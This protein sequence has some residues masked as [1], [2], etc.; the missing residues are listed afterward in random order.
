MAGKRIRVLLAD[1]H[2]KVRE[3][4]IHL[5]EQFPDFEIAGQAI[6][7]Q[8][9]VRLAR[10]LMPDVIIMDVV[11]P[12]MDGI[13]ATRIIHS[14]LPQV[15]VLGLSSSEDAEHAMRR[16]GAVDYICKTAPSDAIIEAIRNCGSSLSKQQ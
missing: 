8:E 5:L 6:D 3:G 10:E 7:G 9:A 13:D 4:L 15:Q 16:A 1:D 12:R 2:S 14:E 11:M